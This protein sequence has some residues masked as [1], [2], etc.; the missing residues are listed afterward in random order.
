M[1]RSEIKGKTSKRKKISGKISACVIS[2]SCHP[3][4]CPTQ[5]MPR[6]PT[7]G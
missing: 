7:P 6:P 3:K 4:Y 1:E 2:F 5:V